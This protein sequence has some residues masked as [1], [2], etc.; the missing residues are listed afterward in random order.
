MSS[1]TRQPSKRP[2]YNTNSIISSLLG[3]WFSL[4]N[5]GPLYTVCWGECMEC[6]RKEM[7][8][9]KY[10]TG[11]LTMTIWTP[12]PP[13][14]PPPLQPGRVR[15]TPHCGPHRSSLSPITT[16]AHIKTCLNTG[17]GGPLRGIKTFCWG[18]VGIPGATIPLSEALRGS[19][20][21]N[22]YFDA[23]L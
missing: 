21:V 2:R 7:S 3:K 1:H 22:H 4:Q 15:R 23:L 16:G 20:W 6:E 17:E 12:P 5:A 11:S 9:T 10:L 8:F 18:P 19:C 14:L 13:T